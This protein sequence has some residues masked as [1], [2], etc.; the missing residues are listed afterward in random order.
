MVLY[1]ILMMTVMLAVS[2]ALNSL[3]ISKL[4]AAESARDAIVAFYAA[5]S[6]SESCLYQARINADAPLTMDNGATY[7]ILNLA[8]NADITADCSTLGSGSF[9]FQATGA[10]HGTSRALEISQ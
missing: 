9:G 6:A 10:F 7:A 2:L 5:D 4:R 3:F 1:A 8:G